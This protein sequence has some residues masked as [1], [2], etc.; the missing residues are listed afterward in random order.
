MLKAGE[1]WHIELGGSKISSE[2]IGHERIQYN[3]GGGMGDTLFNEHARN[4]F[5]RVYLLQGYLH[6]FFLLNEGKCARQRDPSWHCKK[7]ECID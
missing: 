3:D 2:M 5:K 4:V 7:D 1:A 6:F